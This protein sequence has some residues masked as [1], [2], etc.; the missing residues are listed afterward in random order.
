MILMG[1]RWLRMPIFGHKDVNFF[2]FSAKMTK[3]PLATMAFMGYN[4]G[5]YAYIAIPIRL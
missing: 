1:I 4:I 3:L 2:H 5:V